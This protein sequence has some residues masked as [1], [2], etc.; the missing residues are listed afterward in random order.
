MGLVVDQVRTTSV[1]VE[2]PARYWLVPL[3]LA[4]ASA[5]GAFAGSLILSGTL[6]AVLTPALALQYGW[7]DRSVLFALPPLVGGVALGGLAAGRIADRYGTRWLCL[8]SGMGIAAGALAISFA[9]TLDQ[10]VAAWGLAGLVGSGAAPFI[11]A[12]PIVTA[13]ARRTGLLL[14]A[15]AA[16][17]AMPATFG[18]GE[19][20]TLLDSHD[21]RWVARLVGMSAGLAV[22]TAALLL[23][24]VERSQPAEG[25]G[26]ALRKIVETRAF[27]LVLAASLPVTVALGV[28]LSAFGPI[29]IE[30]GLEPYEAGTYLAVAAAATVAGRLVAGWLADRIWLPAAAV[31]LTAPAM[32]VG[33]VLARGAP[34]P[35]AGIVVLAAALGLAAG[36]GLVLGSMLLARYVGPQRFGLAAALLFGA[37]LAGGLLPPALVADAA[38]TTAE[39][40]A[41]V[42]EHAAVFL[43]APMLLIFVGPDLDGS[44]DAARR[45]RKP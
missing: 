4:L 13:G 34:P 6:L 16:G 20:G 1:G 21:W 29:L 9:D 25:L 40:G 23:P 5:L 8:L 33:L 22:A 3:R 31:L 18:T 14:G 19:L 36:S 26:A 17:A 12:Q 42:A 43:F 27:W 41:F 32:L 38:A 37:Q 24:T 39:L 2:P 35:A 30:R 45:R 11:W 10:W 7:T 44:G 28:L 15:A